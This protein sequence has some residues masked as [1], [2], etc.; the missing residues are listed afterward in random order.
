MNIGIRLHDTLPG[1]LKERLAFARAQG[2]S[3]AHVALSKVLDNFSMGEAPEK[4]TDEYALRVRQD[5][6]E[7]G[8][9]CAVLGCYLNLADPDPERRARTQEI[10][11]AHLRFAAKIGARV[12]GTETNA[13]PESRFA[14]PAPQSEEAFRL[15][16]DSLRPVVRCAEETG[17]VLAVE[18]VWYHIISTPERAARMLEELPS[19]NLQIILDAV[20]LISPEQ[21]DRAEEIIKNA[22]SLLGDRVRI[23]HM[24]DF[25]I[26]SEGKMKACACGMGAMRYE[27]L[28]SFAAA[29]SLPMTL[30]NTVPENAETARLHLEG[31]MAAMRE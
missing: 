5:F 3:C 12:V 18:P 7:S 22:V 16:L 15:W 1:N 11:K 24:K 27:Q 25:V 29:R 28:L 26:S 19:D 30:E 20:N 14:D 13:N 17:A 21:V 31:I 6:D 2:F 8:L 4:L 23:L 10:Y 9:E